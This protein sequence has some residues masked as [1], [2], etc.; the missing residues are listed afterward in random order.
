MI[1]HVPANAILDKLTLD[2]Q[3]FV[4]NGFCFQ[5]KPFE[6]L[7]KLVTAGRLSLVMTDITAHEVRARIRKQV[8]EELLRHRQFVNETS[9]LHNSS[10][11][12]V[13]TLMTKLSDDTVV[14]DL[15]TQFEAFLH[16]TKATI[17]PATSLAGDEVFAKYFAGEPP[18]GDA[19]NKKAEFP[20]AFA[21]QALAEWAEEQDAELF[22]VSNDKL[23]RDGCAAYPRLHPYQT[24]PNVLDAVAS[25]D[26]ALSDFLRTQSLVH[27][28][29]IQ[30][31]ASQQFA[32]L[33]FWVEDEDGDVEVEVTDCLI[34][35]EPEI[36]EIDEHEAL[37]LFRFDCHYNAELSYN[38]SATA[39][40]DEGELMYVE[41]RD[42][43]VKRQQELEVEVRVSFDPKDLDTVD[44][45]DVSVTAPSKGF[46]IETEH[47]FGWPWK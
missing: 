30:K 10:L 46:G 41:R 15:L 45:S 34:D 11:A 19:Q 37:L 7:K 14:Q 42:E 32:D 40:Y 47:N 28:A 36:L 29:E 13:K 43:S 23:F 8:T 44:I 17:I 33:G 3:V 26:E 38:D 27:L 12:E 39:S 25:D 22:V 9:S 18:F 20:D 2:T 24:L 31:D 35:G 4:S 21:I 5:S 1:L 6:A 16:E